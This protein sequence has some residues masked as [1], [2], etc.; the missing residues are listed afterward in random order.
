MDGGIPEVR[1]AKSGS[2]HI[3]YQVFGDG[4]ATI[5]AVPPMAQNLDIAWEWPAIRTMFERFGSFSRFLHFDKRGTGLSDRRFDVPGLDERVDDLRVVMDHAGIGRAFLLG[6]SEGGPMA[7]LFAA[8]YPDRVD[9]VILEVSAARLGRSDDVSDEQRAARTAAWEH[10]ISMWGTVDTIM[11]DAFAPSL[12]AD[13]EFRTWWPRYERQCATSTELRT[14]LQMNAEMDVRGILSEVH[15]PVLALCR[16]GDRILELS[17]A[18]ETVAAL[19]D[20]RLVVHEGLDHFTWAAAEVDAILDE[21][22]RFTTGTVQPNRGPLHEP[23][24]EIRTLGRFAVVVDGE[25]VPSSEWGSRRARTLLKRLVAARGWPVTREEL[26]ELLWPDDAGSSRLGARLSVQLSAVRRV[27]NGGVI[28]DRSTVR[29]DL[30]HVVVDLEVLGSATTDDAI[31]DVYDGEFLPE[32]RY[33]DWSRPVRDEA[34]AAFAAAGHR[35]LTAAGPERRAAV[36]RR[37][38]EADPYDEAAHLA[39]VRS[40]AELGRLGAAREAHDAYAEKM[41]E[42]GVEA[43]SFEEVVRR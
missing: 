6:V 32:D 42:L 16:R 38:I 15:Q 31:L 8:T 24:V 5:V 29:L 7:L 25:E 2:S 34:R 22:E 27:L 28:A 12:A 18:E 26:F 41:T 4:P 23:K 11:P 37:L 33:D 43:A 1:F 21:I 17:L 3:A 9:G 10:L 30:D 40:A 35:I 14:L 13:P 39:L 19:P 20:A 36:A